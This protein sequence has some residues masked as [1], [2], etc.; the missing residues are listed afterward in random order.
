MSQK[1][2]VPQADWT[3]HSAVPAIVAGYPLLEVI[4]NCHV[5]TLLGAQASGQ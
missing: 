1:S 5:Q 2:T 4:R 3:A